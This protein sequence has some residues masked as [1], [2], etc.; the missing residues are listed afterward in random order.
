MAGSRGTR[1]SWIEMNRLAK[2]V[3]PAMERGKG[4]LY[5]QLRCVAP[6]TVSD[7]KRES[8]V[9]HVLEDND[10]RVREF[11][12]FQP[13]HAREI[14]RAF[15]NLQPW[16]DRHKDAI[17]D[18]VDKCEAEKLTATEIKKA[19]KESA[20]T[21]ASNGKR[22]RKRPPRIKGAYPVLLC[23]PPWRYDFAETDTREIENQYPTMTP[24][25]LGALKVPA[26]ADSV[27]FLWATAPKLVEALTVMSAWG[28]TYKTNAVWDKGRI[29]MGYWFRGQHELLL[30]GTRGQF[31][32]PEQRLR[33]SSLIRAKRG[34][35][36]EKPTK[37]YG[38]IETMFPMHRGQ[39]CELFARRRRN[40]WIQWGNEE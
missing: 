38:M 23:D 16:D 13:T 10:I 7:W 29:G 30:V 40:G 17:L 21:L 12:H 20:W 19:A 28:F 27:L 22:K 35:H 6:N 8:E 32:P 15:R 9:L 4:Q 25:E 34:R 2:E 24:D 14:A 26:A 33:I 36:S 37:V 11:E 1:C 18:L 5:A 31:S 3:L 39:W